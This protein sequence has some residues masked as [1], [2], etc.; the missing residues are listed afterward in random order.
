MIGGSPSTTERTSSGCLRAGP[1]PCTPRTRSP[2][3]GRGEVELQQ[4]RGEILGMQHRRV[5]L[6]V[7]VRWVGWVITPA[8][9][10]HAVRLGK[11]GDL[12]VPVAEIAETAVYEHH[13]RTRVADQAVRERGPVHQG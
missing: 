12:G 13:R 11:R 2:R 8:V 3:H 6:V 7:V 1:A 4:E 10:E 9:H 5:G